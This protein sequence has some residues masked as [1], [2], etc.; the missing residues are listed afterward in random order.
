MDI[1]TINHKGE[2]VV[3][4]GPVDQN[5]PLQPGKILGT[6][7]EYDAPSK[8]YTDPDPDT[9]PD[10]DPDVIAERMSPSQSVQVADVDG[11]GKPDIVVANFP[12]L[13]PN[14]PTIDMTPNV[15]YFQDDQ[16]NFPTATKLAPSG[17]VYFQDD[18]GNFPTAT[19]L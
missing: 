5:G 10:T 14:D 6:D 12:T 1:V 15:V 18:Q 4:F 13:D 11:D 19:K 8:T 16:G 3:Y 2:N 9:D 17:K 7:L